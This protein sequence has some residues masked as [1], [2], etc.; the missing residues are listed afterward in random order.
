MVP[1]D[2][3]ALEDCYDKVSDCASGE[4]APA[5]TEYLLD[6]LRDVAVRP[7]DRDPQHNYLMGLAYLTGIAVEVNQERARQLIPGLDGARL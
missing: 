6:L 7:H 2:R 4:N 1:T 5:L 3:R